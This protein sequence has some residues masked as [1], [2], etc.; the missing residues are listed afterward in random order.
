[1][2]R[3]HKTPVYARIYPYTRVRRR[4][5]FQLRYRLSLSKADLAGDKNP[6]KH[7]RL[8]YPGELVR[9]ENAIR[10][11]SLWKN[12]GALLRNSVRVAF[13]RMRAHVCVQRR[14]NTTPAHRADSSP[15]HIPSPSPGFARVV[16]PYL[17]LFQHAHETL[18]SRIR[19][20]RGTKK[21]RWSRF[22]REISF[23]VPYQC[24]VSCS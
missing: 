5:S 16:S 4:R 11:K 19:T 8:R 10:G 24:I 22:T 7:E 14:A 17:L 6:A 13:A 15:L 2:F 21:K 9:L 1:M 23:V 20:I 12:L 18:F 3:A